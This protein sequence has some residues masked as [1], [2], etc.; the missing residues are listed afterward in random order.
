[1]SPHEL[2]AALAQR[3]MLRARLER[4]AQQVQVAERQIDVQRSSSTTP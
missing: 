4:G 1:M 2:D 3:D